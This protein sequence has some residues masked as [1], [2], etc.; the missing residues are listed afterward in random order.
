M[1]ESLPYPIQH[2]DPAKV[3]EMIQKDPQ[4]RQMLTNKPRVGFT[5]NCYLPGL[6]KLFQNTIKNTLLEKLIDQVWQGFVRYRC[7]GDNK[8]YR[9]ALKE[10]EKVFTYDDAFLSFLNDSI[11]ES[12]KARNT[13]NDADRKIRI[14]LMLN[15]VVMTML[16]EDL[17][18]RARAKLIIQ[19]LVKQVQENPDLLRLTNHEALNYIH[20]SNFN[21]ETG[22]HDPEKQKALE[23]LRA[24]IAAG[25]GGEYYDGSL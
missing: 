6:G 3:K 2:M 9:E 10:P 16:F 23:P 17:Y 24:L 18:Y 8:V 22:F 14:Q 4:A 13:D 25:K 12:V 21:H 20:F 1:T 19:D 7:H 5:H 15:D 11:R